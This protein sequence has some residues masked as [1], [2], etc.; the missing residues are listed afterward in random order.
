MWNSFSTLWIRILRVRRL[1]NL[2]LELKGLY[3]RTTSYQNKLQNQCYLVV[4]STKAV[5]HA[6]KLKAKSPFLFISSTFQQQ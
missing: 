6:Y 3:P 4:E 1:N 5:T 2:M